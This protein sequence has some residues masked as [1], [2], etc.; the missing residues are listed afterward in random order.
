M[1]NIPPQVMEDIK[2]KIRRP[3]G[4]FTF[5]FT[6]ENL[7]NSEVPGGIIFDIISGAH[8]FRL[9]RDN[10]LKISFYHS[11]PGTGT[12]ISTV[13]LNEITPCSTVFI[14]FTWTTKNIN[15]YVGPRTEGGEI[16]SSEGKPSSRQLIVGKDGNVHEIG[17]ANV[18][19]MDI[20][21]Y[22]NG[23]LILQ[24]TALD[25]WKSTVI[26]VEMLHSG[27]SDKGH[28]FDVVV[29]NLTIAILVTG[30]ETYCKRRFLEL[31]KEGIIP[32]TESLIQRFSYKIHD[33]SVISSEAKAENKT[34]LQK[35][36]EEVINFQSYEECKRAYNKA[37][38]LKFSN[39]GVLP[40]NLERFQKFISYRH[41]II[42][43]SALLGILNQGRVPLEEPEFSNRELAEEVIDS[44]KTFINKLHES[45]LSLKRLE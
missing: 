38:G 18:E 17:D 26:A 35:L 4:T 30:F 34:I 9:E 12:R 19:V 43:V 22:E 29:T 11:S 36:A 8:I 37:Y 25:T 7:F 41:R 20:T 3:E 14:A 42:H 2:E 10:K 13:D 15:L 32:Q 1:Y 39:I 6:S 40:H 24:P 27:S 23:Q 33:L 28:I 44:F 45:T 21:I 16:I 5:N 31:E